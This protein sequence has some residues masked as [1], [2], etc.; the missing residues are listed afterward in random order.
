MVVRD[1]RHRWNYTHAMIER[2]MLLRRSAI[3][4]W[5]F[6]REELRPLALQTEDWNHLEALGGLLKVSVSI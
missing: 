2:G 5:V 6:D 4:S 1:S 3:D